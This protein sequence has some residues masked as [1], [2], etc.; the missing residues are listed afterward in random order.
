MR[1]SPCFIQCCDTSHSVAHHGC[2]W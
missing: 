2:I 1:L